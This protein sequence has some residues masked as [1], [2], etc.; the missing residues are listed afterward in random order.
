MREGDRVFRMLLEI[1]G[2]HAIIGQRCIPRQGK[3]LFDN[4]LRVP[5]NLNLRPVAFIVIRPR[6]GILPAV[7]TPSAHTLRIGSLSHRSWISIQATTLPFPFGTN[8]NCQQIH[9]FMCNCLAGISRRV[10]R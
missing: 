6:I 7:I 9:V 8:L 1:F 2:R 5:P 10:Y 4:L 3:I